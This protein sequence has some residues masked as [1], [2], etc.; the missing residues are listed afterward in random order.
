MNN[1]GTRNVVSTGSIG[2]N[3]KRKIV[4]M[5]MLESNSVGPSFVPSCSQFNMRFQFPSKFRDRVDGYGL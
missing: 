2:S 4:A 5:F 1:W 3:L